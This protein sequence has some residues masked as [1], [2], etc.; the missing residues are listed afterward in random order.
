[1]HES[2]YDKTKELNRA[3]AGLH[4]ARESKAE[5]ASKEGRKQNS[6][7]YRV[8]RISTVSVGNCWWA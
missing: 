7:S 8:G 6:I 1:M 4:E 3:K 5:N 2:E